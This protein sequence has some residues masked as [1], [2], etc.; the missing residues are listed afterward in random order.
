MTDFIRGEGLPFF[1]HLLKR[2]SDEFVRGCAEWYPDAGLQTPPRCASTVRALFRRGPLSVTELAGTI[3]QS[4][5][6]AINWVREL[7]K[8]GLVE[9]ASDPD[10]G[11]RTLVR[12][13]EA[14][15]RE[16]ERCIAT[17]A[18]IEQAYSD[19]MKEADAEVFDALWRM[20]ALCRAVPFEERLRVASRIGPHDGARR[21]TNSDDA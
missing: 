3:R 5:P 7:K 8:L 17:D 20:E 13:T 12:L 4:H 16:A 18:V 9:T 15:L 6:L 14:G 21:A 19:L 11:R 1:A 10:D 2:L